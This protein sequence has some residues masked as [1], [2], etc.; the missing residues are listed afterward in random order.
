MRKLKLAVVSTHPIQYYAPVFRALARSETI[1]PRIFYTW[2]QAAGGTLFDPEFATHLKWDVPLTDGYEHEYVANTA[3]NPSPDHFSGIRNPAL[4]AAIEAWGADAL[5]V[6]AWNL[7]S[8]LGALRHF[9]GRVP[10]FFRGDST[11]LEPR[12]P[13]RRLARRAVLRWVYR[14]VDVA[15]CVGSHSKEYFAWC[16]VPPDRIAFAPHSVDTPRFVDGDGSHEAAASAWRRRLGIPDTARVALFAAKLV[17]AKNPQ[18]LLD[19]FTGLEGEGHLVIVGSGAL[20]GV[21]KARAA[22]HPRVHFLPFQNQS[23]MPAVYRLGDVFVLPSRSESWGLALNE[24][25]AC[26]RPV[27]ASS[28]V[29]AARDLVRESNGWTFASDDTRACAQVLQMALETDRDAL[30]AM[31]R[32]GQRLIQSWSTDAAARGIE[33]AVTG[34]VKAEH[35]HRA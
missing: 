15:V 5:L 20:E 7:H 33:S 26:A 1:E 22:G 31:G 4:N 17:D 14:H 2:S 12:P 25:M 16:G 35:R 28:R 3:S 13:L 9:K 18:V 21:L 10:V 8:H 6:Y 24:A 19:A 34:F 27:I 11:L 30:H 23:V 29:A 32:A